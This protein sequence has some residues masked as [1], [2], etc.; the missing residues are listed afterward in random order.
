MGSAQLA[1]HR[2]HLT[3]GGELACQFIT[4]NSRID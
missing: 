2:L 1:N 4:L 3:G